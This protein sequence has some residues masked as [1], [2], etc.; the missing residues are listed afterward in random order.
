[1][2]SFT[3]PLLICW[4]LCGFTVFFPIRNTSTFKVHA[5]SYRYVCITASGAPQNLEQSC[6]LLLNDFLKERL[7]HFFTRLYVFF[8]VWWWICLKDSWE[9]NWTKNITSW[10]LKQ[11][12]W[13]ICSSNRQI[14]SFPQGSGWKLKNTW[15]HHSDHT[16]RYL[17]EYFFVHWTCL[18]DKLHHHKSP[19]NYGPI[20]YACHPTETIFR[21][22]KG[23]LC[24]ENIPIEML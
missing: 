19:V 24:G 1:M 9:S 3:N 8:S 2:G 18:V 10:W 17:K 6:R 22:K 4:C 23:R 20:Y 5:S 7:F 16:S 15:N 11:P 14:R 12:I 21:K 13:E